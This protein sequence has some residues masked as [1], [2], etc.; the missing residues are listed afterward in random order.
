M[1]GKVRAF[2]SCSSTFSKIL[3]FFSPK[4]AVKNPIIMLYMSKSSI[5]IINKDNASDRI[6]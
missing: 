6:R 2:N 1:G 3:I 5:Q 4:I